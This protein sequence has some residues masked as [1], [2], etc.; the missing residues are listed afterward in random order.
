MSSITTPFPTPIDLY[1]VIVR[2][3]A[4][5]SIRRIEDR[6]D[7]GIVQVDWMREIHSLTGIGCAFR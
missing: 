4:D 1:R 2:V 7:G 6:P 3:W 5:P